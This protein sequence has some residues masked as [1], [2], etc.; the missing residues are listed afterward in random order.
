MEIP[1]IVVEVFHSSGGKHESICDPA[2]KHFLLLLIL[3]VSIVARHTV[4]VG[5]VSIAP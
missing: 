3:N 4:Y 1:L 5:L 2:E